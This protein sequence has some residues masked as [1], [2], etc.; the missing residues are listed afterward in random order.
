[1]EGTPLYFVYILVCHD[2]TFY[3]GYTPDLIRRL[4]TH[5]AGRGAKYT[6]ARTPVYLIYHEV[7]LDRHEALRREYRIKQLTRQ[8][9]LA[10][11]T[12]RPFC[13]AETAKLFAGQRSIV[14]NEAA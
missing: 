11:A 7:F 2:G 3:T 9:K 4:K 5:N 1:M 8:E 10:L 6:K 12:G 13:L 14:A